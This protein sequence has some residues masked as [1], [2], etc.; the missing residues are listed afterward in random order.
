MEARTIV[1][2]DAIFEGVLG[3][4]VVVGGATGWLGPD[5]FAGIGRGVVVA[6]GVVLL[7]AAAILW[8]G[9]IRV[10]TLA[11]ANLVTAVAGLVWLGVDSGFS[12]A[13]ATIVAVT[14]VVLLCLAVMQAATLR[15]WAPART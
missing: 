2:A 15:W 12:S 13:G 14:T 6:L 5:D 11:I 3:L 8:R 9:R 7:G 1:R 10:A 4:T